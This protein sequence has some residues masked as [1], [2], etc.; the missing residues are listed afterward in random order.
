[1]SFTSTVF[2]VFLLA[3]FFAYWHLRRR[4]QLWFLLAANCVFY[5]Y[6]NWRFLPVLFM[7]AAVNYMCGARISRAERAS[8]KRTWLLLSVVTSLTA[9]GY[10]KYYNFFAD[11]LVAVASAMGFGISIPMRQIILPLGISYYVLQMLTYTLDIHRGQMRPTRSPLE[12]AVFTS[13]FAHLVAGPITRARQLL[14]QLQKERRFNPALL[15]A[16]LRRILLG[17]FKKL[18]V[19]DILASYLVDPVFASPGNYTQT[20]LWL[21]LVGYAVQIYADFSG[22]SS[23]AIG[24]ARLLG[25]ALPENFSFPY[26]SVNIAEFWRRWHITLS[27]WLRDYLWWALAKSTPM[28]GG[29]K[30]RLR[31]QYNLFMVFLICGLWHGASWTF[32]AWG[33]LHGLYMVMY[34]TWHRRRPQIA[35]PQNPS[36]PFRLVI[37][38]WLLTQVGLLLSW[39]LFRSA[40]FGSCLL[41]LRG[42]V[43]SNGTEAVHITLP[44][45][46]AF[47]SFAV[48]HVAGWILEHR[49]PAVTRLP[50]LAVAAAYVVLL[51]VLFNARP[52]QTSQFIYFQF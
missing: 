24:V 26:L 8:T 25:F 37:P 11:S 32:V 35:S 49:P 19:A 22:Y 27:R 5:A 10:F 51:L 21:A 47:S 39:V 48:D 9:L 31:S 46:I 28:T 50:V 29:L 38:A 17:L 41:Y 43:S 23:M 6:W 34:D 40:T 52:E 42:L 33:A 4:P 14:P 16:G 30:V 20:T 1:M 44:V 36:T 2:A 18:C 15:E 13:F 3:V 7:L 45:I 12:F